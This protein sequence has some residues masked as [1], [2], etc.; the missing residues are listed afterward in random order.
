MQSVDRK[1]GT[2]CASRIRR[3]H[4]HRLR[5]MMLFLI[6]STV[7]S[8]PL[9]KGENLSL[10]VSPT[11]IQMGAFYNG[12]QMRVEGTVPAGSHVVVVIRGDEKH[13]IFNRKGRVGPIWLNVDKVHIQNAP[14][15]FLTYSSENVR[16]L[17]DGATVEQYQM[18]QGAIKKRMSPRIHCQCASQVRPGAAKVTCKGVEPPLQEGELLRNSYLKLKAKEGTYQAF[19]Q[20]VKISEAG[21]GQSLYRVDLHWP[22]K[23]P[24][25]I[26]QVEV[27][28]VRDRAIVAR[29]STALPV[30]EIGF[31]AFMASLAGKHPWIYGLLAVLAAVVA[32]FGMDFIAVRLRRPAPRVKP[33]AVPVPEAAEPALAAHVDE[34]EHVER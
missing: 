16:S 28:A 5:D 8:S 19:S 30:V 32:G 6:A 27:Y 22:R 3:Q 34:E 14:A 29:A 17:L 18:D 33:R 24:P 12:A 23:A 26:Y 1:R 9:M 10:N 15:L 2:G 7:F 21:N 13:E 31:P 25:A 4:R 11:P 20:A